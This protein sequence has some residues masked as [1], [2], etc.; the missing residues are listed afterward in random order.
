LAPVSG[1]FNLA[2]HSD[3]FNLDLIVFVGAF[4]LEVWIAA[5]LLRKKLQRRFPWFVAYTF[6]SIVVTLVRIILLKG[7]PRTYFFVYWGTE[8]L[9]GLLGVLAIYESFKE[10]FEP[11]Y[12]FPWFRLL[13]I[14]VTI[15]PLGG[16]ALHFAVKPPME[17]NRLGVAI[18]SLETG[19]RYVQG[20]IYVLTSILV[21]VFSIPTRRYPAGIVEGFGA[22]VIGILIGTMF[23]SEFGIKFNSLLSFSPVVGY[24]VALLIWLTSL[25]GPDK[26][27]GEIEELPLSPEDMLAYL[28]RLI[29]EAKRLVER[30]WE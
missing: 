6:Y 1:W 4:C 19:V 22:V 16:L 13:L 7:N 29:N 3:M 23:R 10:M 15:V 26:R 8:S 5:L 12:K 27:K 28:L 25:H 24:I 18:L 17:A 11:L 20:C 2:T 9:Y 14:A 30:I 21:Y